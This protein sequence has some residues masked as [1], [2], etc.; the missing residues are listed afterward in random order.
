[1]Y[2]YYVETFMDDC[3]K[4]HNIVPGVR[5]YLTLEKAKTLAQKWIV[6]YDIRH[7]E[8]GA[9]TVREAIQKYPRSL[10]L[11]IDGLIYDLFIS[12]ILSGLRKF[13]N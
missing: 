6:D 4:Y 11:L 2:L 13:F 5:F 1:M 9:M 3:G 8:I 12:H 10:T 7:I